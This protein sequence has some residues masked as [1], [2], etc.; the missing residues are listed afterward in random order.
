MNPIPHYQK[1]FVEHWHMNKTDHIFLSALS[2]T[3]KHRSG[4]PQGRALPYKEFLRAIAKSHFVTSPSGDRP[5][6]HRHY[7]ALGLGAIPITDLHPLHYRHLEH[8]PIVYGVTRW[9]LTQLEHFIPL[10]QGRIVNRNMAFEE[11][12]MESI[13]R[14]VGHPLRWWDRLQGKS[15]LLSEFVWLN[16]T[17]EEIRNDILAG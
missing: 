12:W 17:A 1:A 9:N 5:E 10:Y 7:E 13:D 4:V 6:C 15:C 3:N 8:G 2:A 14:I 16:K 11:Y